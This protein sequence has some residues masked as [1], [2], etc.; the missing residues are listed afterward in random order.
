MITQHQNFPFRQAMV[1][2]R[3]S[4]KTPIFDF[5][6]VAAQ[7]ELPR[8]NGQQHSYYCGSHFGFGLHEEAVSSA[9]Q[10]V[11]QLGVTFQ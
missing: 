1:D 10:V 9:I 2:A 5:P 8:L 7:A 11:E 6:A 4:F 3:F